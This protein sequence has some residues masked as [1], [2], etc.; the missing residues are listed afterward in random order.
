[1]KLS[2]QVQHCWPLGHYYS[3]VP[4]TIE[5]EREPTRSRV[6]PDAPPPM[7]G[8]DWRERDQLSFLGDRLAPLDHLEF[9][10]QPTGRLVE[11]HSTN[12]FFGLA[13]AW[14][15]QAMLQHLRPARMIEVGGGWSSLVTARV[16]R[17]RLNGELDFTCI[18]PYP[19]D[20]LT[21][22]IDGV[23]RLISARVQD[24]PVE[25][26]LTLE[27]GDVLFIDTSHVA[28]TGGD[29]QYLYHE[30]VPRLRPGV[31]VHIHD[32]FLPWDY[33]DDWVLSGRGWNE[34]YLVRSFLAFNECF[35]VTL[36][37]AWLCRT[38]PDLIGATIPAFDPGRDGGASLWIRRRQ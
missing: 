10:D 6:W 30:V 14:T 5:L 16:N 38:H 9:P 27:A 36:A 7:V 12:E 37:V 32:V 19:A 3:P 13:D 18:E 35:E 34:Q 26:F 17:E 20:F 31:V 24:M 8:I 15:L 4:D 1:M 21:D 22:R 28:K 33:P 25:R 23:S 2:A 29:V 11:Y